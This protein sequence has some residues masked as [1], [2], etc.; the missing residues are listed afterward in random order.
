MDGVFSQ[1]KQNNSWLMMVHSFYSMLGGYMCGVY[2]FLGARYPLPTLESNREPWWGPKK[3][4][5]APSSA[6]RLYIEQALDVII[7]SSRRSITGFF[8]PKVMNDL[9]KALLVT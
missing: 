3:E 4:N 6:S 1:Q 8:H 9:E 2:Q 5:G 7:P